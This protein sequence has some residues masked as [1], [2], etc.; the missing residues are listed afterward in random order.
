MRTL[1]ISDFDLINLSEKGKENFIN[2]TLKEAGFD[3]DKPIERYKIPNSFKWLFKQ[4][5]DD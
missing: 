3:L 1:E 2:R 5:E 4:E